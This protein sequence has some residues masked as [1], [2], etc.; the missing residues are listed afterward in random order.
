MTIAWYARKAADEGTGYKVVHWKGWLA[1]AIAATPGTYGC[2]SALTSSTTAEAIPYV[3]LMLLS[4][5]LGGAVIWL[6]S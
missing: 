1:I 6:R 3:G 4:A 5:A 2:V